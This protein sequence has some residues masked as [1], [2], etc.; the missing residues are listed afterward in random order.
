MALAV[1]TSVELARGWFASRG[2]TPFAFQE[3][4][5]RAYAAGR[6]GLI[7]VPTGA[8]K[9][10]AA[11]LAAL[12][13]VVGWGGKDDAERYPLG[14]KGGDTK[15]HYPLRAA[16]SGTGEAGLGILYVTPL[17]AVARDIELA[18]KEPV[19]DLGLD[20]R[21]ES[22][23]GDTSS[24]VK[25]R[26]RRKMPDVLV[27]TPESLS[28]MLTYDESREMFSGLRALIIDEWHELL[29]SK[30][31][32]Q[33]ELAAA[34]LRR[35]APGMRTWA[36]SATLANTENAARAAVGVG[37]EPVL[38]GE[39][40]DRPVV[41][42][43]V[44]ME[45]VRQMPW[46]GH[47]GMRMKSDLAELL[48]PSRSTLVF[49]NTRSQA[50]LWFRALLNERPEWEGRIAIHHGS[51]DRDERERVEAG[52]KSGQIGIVVC[53]SSL[54]LGV[55]FAPVERI[56]QIGS[57][58]GVARLIQRAGRSGHRPGEKARIWCVPTHALELVEVA[59]VRA[60][61]DAGHVEARTPL[62]KPLDVLAQHMVTCALGGGFVAA[63][64][65]EEVRTAWAFR[66]LTD[67]EF[68][69]TLELVHAGGATL[70]AYPDFHRVELVEGVYRVPKKKI[71]ALHR[72][73]VGTITSEATM[74]L[75]YVSGR[76]IGTIEED[77]I[78]TLRRGDR[79][80]FGGKLLEFVGAHGME[81]R[82]RPAKKK[83][84][85]TPRWAGTKLPITESLA[86]AVRD[87]LEAAREGR[88][89]AP[90]LA[91]VKPIIDTQARLSRVPAAD[92]LLVELARTREGYHCFVFPFDGRLV[93][94][95]LAALVAY[96]MT[97]VRSASFS[98]AV[99]DYGM[100]LLTDEAFP[101]R[102]ALE[103]GLFSEEGLLEDTVASLNMS[104]LARRQFRDIARVAGLVFQSRPG[105]PEGRRSARHLQASTS[106]IYDVFE[107]FDPGNL[108]LAQ[109]RREVLERQF[110]QSRL[111]RTL[112]RLRGSRLVVVET[113]RP[114]PL[115]LPLMVERLGAK[116]SSETL[117]ERIEKM[118]R[119]WEEPEVRV[120]GR[121]ARRAR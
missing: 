72:M 46:A 118:Q 96:R 8:G 50:E 19:A 39:R 63:D 108:L 110:E 98:I 42:E 7:H 65:R 34:R 64:L 91:A 16:G 105:G 17:R 79:F 73:N 22:R 67:D 28:L 111:G 92:E 107:Q 20:V 78:S 109:A 114:T 119:Q 100:E 58:K 47:L 102:E 32:S 24:S 121:V 35:F 85:Y 120:V 116:L 45:D 94:G 71:A 66:T 76:V 53:T 97:R 82:V 5:W 54:D 36:L 15:A 84:T 2:W 70:K 44:M 115:S 117:A 83:T 27:T 74:S 6:S 23:T 88:L 26:Q 55:D 87:A 106:L 81:A 99:N 80:A 37:V 112:A 56:V 51:I 68:A 69:W 33:V 31:G 89:E 4:A 3:E 9:T 61:I 101:Y 86:S 75:R 21:V 103:A 13:E 48:D 40:L 93:H 43:S 14:T 18:L 29:S 59:A 57:P 49:T 30:R 52:V 77:F 11:Y 41:I 104:E 90:E 95:G 38:V 10:Y 12:G 1:G 62:D 113:P 25:A 60:A